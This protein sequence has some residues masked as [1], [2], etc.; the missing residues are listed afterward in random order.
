MAFCVAF[1]GLQA[2]HQAQIELHGFDDLVGG[3]P[4]VVSVDAEEG[5]IQ[6]G[7]DALKAKNLDVEV[8][9]YVAGN[10]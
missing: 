2:S 4:L 7:L 9:G 5:R 8:I 6:E 10:D 3:D 1:V